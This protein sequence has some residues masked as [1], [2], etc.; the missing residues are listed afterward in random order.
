M[1]E[2]TH[3]TI[4]DH[5][6]HLSLLRSALFHLEERERDREWSLEE[7]IFGVARNAGFDFLWEV[8]ERRKKGWECGLGKEIKAVSSHVMTAFSTPPTPKERR[9]EKESAR[10]FTR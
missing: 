2:T 5:F 10:S 3:A 1:R 4:Y 9:S 8:L 7:E 6:C